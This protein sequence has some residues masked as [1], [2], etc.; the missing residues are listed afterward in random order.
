MAASTSTGALG[1]PRMGPN[2]ELKFSLERFWRG[3][4]T[5]DQLLSVARGI[6]EKSWTLQTD[7]GLDKI[8]VGD[9]VLYDTMVAWTEYLGAIP[10]R[11]SSLSPGNARMFALARGVKGATALDMTKWFDSNYHYEVPELSSPATISPNFGAYFE[12]VSRG[13]ETLGAERAT[14]LVLGPVTWVHLAKSADSTDSAETTAAIKEEYLAA[15]LPV[16]KEVIAKLA[17]MGVQEVL[18]SEPAMVMC[19]ASPGL[20]AMYKTAY[21]PSSELSLLPCPEGL[22]VNMVTYFEDVGSDM[23]QWLIALPVQIITLDFTRGDSLALLREHGF[24][25]DKILGAGVID[26][27]TPWAMQP[28][29]VTQVLKAVS[30]I[31]KSVRVQASSPLQFVPWD[32]SGETD[33]N[34][35]VGGDVIAFAAQKLHEIAAVGAAMADIAEGKEAEEIFP[36]QTAAWAAFRNG[37]TGNTATAERLAALTPESFKRPAPFAERKEAQLKALNV[38]IL[39][40]TTIGSFPQTPAVRKLRRDFKAGVLSKEA[41]ENQIDQQIAYAIGVQQEALGLDILVHGE[42]ERTDMVE[43]F[44]QQLEGMAF[45]NNGWVQSYGS[46]CVRPPIICGDISR[47]EAM[48]V[49]EF[50]VAQNM[51][52]KPV[53]GMLTG[54]ITI[55]NWSFPRTDLPRKDQA[56]QLALALADEVVDLENAGCKVIQMDEPALREGMPLKPSKKDEYLLWSVDSFLL[57][58]AIAKSETSI[59]THMCYCEFQ[60]CMG[61]IDRMDCDVNSIENARSDNTTLMAF[62]SI[63]Y[64]KGLGPGTYDIHSPVVPPKG[65]ITEKI[66]G[67][68]D[69]LPP[70]QLVVNPDCGLKTRTWP[71]VLGALRN[72]VQATEEVRAEI[73]AITVEA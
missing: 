63:D 39:P 49:R 10:E 5:E 52:L 20:D 42:A 73:N 27:R 6:E 37:I 2:R 46:R 17:E 48:T 15:L 22:S 31:T 23:Y 57:S 14:P 26:G 34:S 67:F 21:D 38:P 43:Y 59:H 55:L 61:A 40:T 50:V 44:G 66:N 47:P 28:K 11:F 72:M 29:K 36:D 68:L 45:T 16:Y 1:F 71:Q 33:L 35:R 60:D 12:N 65:F 58:T 69:C 41:Y 56:F 4:I 25:E 24:P 9:Y 7:A 8:T 3:T 30:E 19:E 32:A 54:P 18:I 13:L 53:K 62:K 51:T 70:D 64:D